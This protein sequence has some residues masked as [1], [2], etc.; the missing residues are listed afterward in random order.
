MEQYYRELAEIMHSIYPD[1]AFTVD[2]VKSKLR[3][4][5]GQYREEKK[6][7][8]ILQRSGSG[9]EEDYSFWLWPNLWFLSP[10][11]E[12]KSGVDSLVVSNDFVFS[13][14]FILRNTFQI[15]WDLQLILNTF[16]IVNFTPS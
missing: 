4:I 2:A 9:R 8:D 1:T 13:T 6:K 15:L 10:F 14:K 7:Q 16:K 12:I 3:T 5:K 11:V